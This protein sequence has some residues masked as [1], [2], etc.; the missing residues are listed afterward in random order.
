VADLSGDRLADLAIGHSGSG[1][2]TL[3]KGK[4][5]KARPDGSF[6]L[7]AEASSGAL[8]VWIAA[9]DVTGDR[10]Q[11]LL[12]LRAD[13][14]AEVLRGLA[15]GQGFQQGWKQKTGAAALS[16]IVAD[17]T[18]D[19]IPDWV[20]AHETSLEIW[21]GNGANGCPDGTFIRGSEILLSDRVTGLNVG[22]LNADRIPDL[23]LLH[24]DL[25]KISVWTGEGTDGQATGR[26][27]SPVSFNVGAGP[28]QVALRDLNRDGILDLVVANQQEASLSVLVGRGSAGQGDGTFAAAT[29]L[30]VVDLPTSIAVE[31][32]NGDG[33][34]DLLVT[35]GTT[36]YLSVLLGLGNAT[37]AAPRRQLLGGNPAGIAITDLDWDGRRDLVITD[38]QSPQVKMLR[39]GGTC[40]NPLVKNAGN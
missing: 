33:I 10:I 17:V 38:S 15:N 18:S 40:T 19:Q 8:P 1:K 20:I 2:L 36:G 35:H 4:G 7:A 11:D 12:V 39:G 21:I 24:G 16:A 3:W 26:F 13:G 23:V 37:F 14:Q 6:Q 29:K 30:D 27:S 31:D 25:G 5:Q 32:I 28:G 34:A 22:D 9:R